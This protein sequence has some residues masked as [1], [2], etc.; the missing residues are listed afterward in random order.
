MSTLLVMQII[1]IATI[2]I[3]FTGALIAWRERPEPGSVSLTV[4]LAGQCWWSATLF[5][6]INETGMAEKIF[7]TDVTWLGVAILPVAWLFFCLSYTGYIEYLEVRYLL[8]A[9]VVPILTIGFGL[10]NDIHHLMYTDSVLVEQGGSMILDRTPG[11]WFWV[12][13]AYTYLLGILGAILL[14]QFVSSD[15]FLFRG[16]S[17]ALLLGLFIPWVTNV[18]H[19]LGL[20]PTG[21]I[22]PTPV[23]FS[24]SAVLFLGALTRFQLLGTSP[25]PIRPA[26]RSMFRRMQEGLIVLDRRNNIVDMND[27]A[28]Q[29]VGSATLGSPVESVIPQFENIR[30]EQSHSGR[31]VFHSTDGSRVYDISINELTDT[32]D[33][34]TGQIITLHDISEYVRQQ[35]RLEVLNRVFRHNIRTNIQVILSQTEVLADQDDEGRVEK[36]REKVLEIEEFSDKIHQILDVFERGRAELTPVRLGIIVQDCL[37]SVR[38]DYPDVTVHTDLC[39]ETTYVHGVLDD[40]LSNI[41]ENAATHNTNADPTVWV[42][43]TQTDDGVRIVVEDNGPGINDDELTLLTEGT[44]TP[45]KHGSGLGLALIVWGTELTGGEV[46]FEDNDPTGTVVTV[47]AP[48]LSETDG[49]S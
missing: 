34:P 25:T 40:V 41:I 12:I 27:R 1:L 18:T 33:R 32:H 49:A 21:G 30:S 6:R 8:V 26:R 36:T 16:Q 11:V 38:D 9:S 5:F 39:S 23:A 37:N 17:L 13:A 20:L 48:V 35:Q 31:T 47:E 44:E 28:A 2:A 29:A 22:D 43:V 24:L 46:I 45:L 15:V 7:W 4:L 3:G 42:D 10:T 14:L 19:L